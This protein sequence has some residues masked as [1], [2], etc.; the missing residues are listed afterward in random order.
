MAVDPGTHRSFLFDAARAPDHNVLDRGDL[1]RMAGTVRAVLVGAFDGEGYLF[2][3]EPRLYRELLALVR[4][5]VLLLLALPLAGCVP[6]MDG[7]GAVPLAPA[8]AEGIEFDPA[9]PELTA[10]LLLPFRA[11]LNSLGVEVTSAA[12]YRY[13]G[14]D[15][16]AFIVA[17][18]EFYRRNPGHCPL[19]E[20]F[21]P[22]PDGL[23]FMTV[24]GDGGRSVRAFVYDQSRRPRLRF[25]YLEG[26]ASRALPVTQCRTPS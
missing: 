24:T 2:V 26:S 6:A 15:P 23:R 13:D 9:A 20:A 21:Y 22:A 14:T 4:F 25:L 3:L 5:L 10:E 7:L 8:A 16:N 19:T 12:P 11:D 17:I 1:T 18:N